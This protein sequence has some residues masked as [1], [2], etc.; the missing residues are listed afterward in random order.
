[1][2]IHANWFPD[3]I[4][5]NEDL[6]CDDSVFDN[7]AMHQT[8]RTRTKMEN[9]DTASIL[10][11]Q[12]KRTTSRENFTSRIENGALSNFNNENLLISNPRENVDYS[13]EPSLG[14]QMCRSSEKI[15]A[16]GEPG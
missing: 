3:S 4:D 5:Y 13:K 2:Q 15:I 1:M 16:K 7:N 8:I 6:E 11:S 9:P 10:T 14:R 12:E